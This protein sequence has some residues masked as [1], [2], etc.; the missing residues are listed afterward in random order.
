MAMFQ[1]FVGLE[2]HIHLL[3]KTKVFCGC[4]SAYGDKPNTNICPVCLG[5]PG[6]LPTV[7]REALKMS[8]MVGKAMNCELSQHTLFER[9]NY[10]Y[11]DMT[12]NYQITQFSDPVGVNGWYEFETGGSRKQIRIH[13][14]HL[15]E[16]A[17]KMIHD[18]NS[19]LLDDNRAG[20]SL[21]EVVTEPDFSSSEEAED[22]LQSFRRMVRHLGV[23]D[24]NMEEG[25]L[26]CDAN[27]SINKKGKGLGTKV[28]I[29]N[30]NSSRFVRKALQYEYKRQ[31]KT[32]KTG[33]KIIQE[34]RLWN[35]E[36]QKTRSMRTKEAAHDYRY[37]PEPD[38]PPFI[39]DEAFMQNVNQSMVE[40]PLARKQRMIDAYFLTEELAGFIVEEK[41][42]ADFF[43]TVVTDDVDAA[44]AAKWLK[45]ET[46]K[47]LGRRNMELS[48][49]P[50]LAIRFINL[51]KMLADGTIHANIARQLLELILDQDEDPE[52]L[53]EREGLTGSDDN[54]ELAEIIDLVVSNNPEAAV[55]IQE[56]N[57]KAVGFLMGQVMKASQGSADP[58]AVRSLLMQ[59]LNA[60]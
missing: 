37:F 45:G 11:P 40:L 24:G 19:S 4:K 5:Y 35:E 18:G 51:M 39:P 47:Q 1:T 27:I 49:S 42:R 53:L 17:G 57:T 13:D 26:R 3:T 15:E 44:T 32:I 60:K 30:L 59:K 33:G 8:Y 2:I 50:L 7:N 23:C 28:E 34:T 21:L 58:K 20:T 55:Q 22:F 52:I 14:I 29:K 43:E 16:D 41:F 9:K 46:V 6:V 56:G 54:A 31:A 36:K 25:S 10:F 38:I 48:D 12:K